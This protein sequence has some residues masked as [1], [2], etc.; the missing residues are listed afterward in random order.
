MTE[1]QILF[2]WHVDSYISRLSRLL[3][4]IQN[5]S[6]K[7][8]MESFSKWSEVRGV[9]VSAEI[10]WDMRQP[11]E[12]YGFEILSI[13]RAELRLKCPIAI[14]SFLSE[15]WLRRRFPILDFPQHHPF[16]HLPASPETFIQTLR[17]G[18]EA[19][20]YRLNDIIMSYCDLRGR[21]AKLI[22]HGNGF[23]QITRTLG[24]DKAADSLFFYC[25]DD[26]QLF[27]KY[28]MNGALGE[29]I[30]TLGHELEV[31]LRKAIQSKSTEQLLATKTDFDSLLFE[32]GNS[33]KLANRTSLK[34]E[35]K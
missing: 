27:R 3:A 5:V 21:L 28:L 13:L 4:G 1:N 11:A 20:E 7:E 22:T 34:G 25:L 2:I 12:L 17:E 32:L 18:E 35:L 8:E 26:L 16:M 30:L 33:E 19:D 15:P 29:T 9:V 6:S 23:R 10:R 14:C 31:N 24:L